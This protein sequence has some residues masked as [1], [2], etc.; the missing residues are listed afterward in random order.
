MLGDGIVSFGTAVVTVSRR[1][2]NASPKMVCS[3][4]TGASTCSDGAANTILPSSLRNSTFM[5]SSTTREM[6]PSW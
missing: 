2:A 3:R 1:N 6:P 5:E 4:C